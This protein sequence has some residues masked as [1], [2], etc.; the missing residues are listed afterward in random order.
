VFLNHLSLAR[1]TYTASDVKFYFVGE[2]EPQL[3]CSDS[4][5]RS[6]SKGRERAPPTVTMKSSH[7]RTAISFKAKHTV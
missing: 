7:R 6:L 2:T 3:A 1:V 5:I 4:Q